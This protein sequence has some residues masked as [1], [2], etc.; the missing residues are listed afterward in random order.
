MSVE[1]LMRE[2]LAAA[3]K[4]I[5]DADLR[6][7]ITHPELSE[8]KKAL[9]RLLAAAWERGWNEGAAETKAAVEAALTPRGPVQ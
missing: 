2:G 7:A 4:G 3:P 1:D 5:D 8:R 6:D 9:M